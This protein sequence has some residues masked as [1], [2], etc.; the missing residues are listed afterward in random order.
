MRI[1][2]M[3]CHSPPPLT[4]ILSRDLEGEAILTGIANMRTFLNMAT[5][6]PDGE[7]GGSPRSPKLS[8]L[9]SDCS[10]VS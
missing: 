3:G 5:R 8:L 2:D 9:Q 4:E 10:I 1:R 7:N 6:S